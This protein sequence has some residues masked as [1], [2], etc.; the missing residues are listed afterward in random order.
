MMKFILLPV[1]LLVSLFA[2][3]QS[4]IEENM[5]RYYEDYLPEKIF[6]HTDKNIYAG[7]ET[8]WMAVYLLNGQSHLPGAFSQTVWVEIHNGQGEVVA[9]QKLFSED[10]FMAGDL[11]L[12]ASIPPGDYQLAAY[13]NYQRNSGDEMLF[14][15]TIQIL[16]GLKE[17]GGVQL[18]PS[19]PI[20]PAANFSMPHVNLRFFPEGGDC[21]DGVPCR[22]TFVAEGQNGQPY[23]MSGHLENDVDGEMAKIKTDKNGI[24]SFVYL[25]NKDRHFR[26]VLN[27]SGKTID[28]PPALEKGF[29]LR[30]IKRSDHWRLMLHTNVPQGLSGTRLVVHF[31]GYVLVNKVFSSSDGKALI[32][33]PF[34]SLRP[35]VNIATLFD[36][37]NLPVAERLFFM[38]PE[39][40][41]TD[42]EISMEQPL[43]TTRKTVNLNVKMPMDG[44]HVDSMASG[45]ISYSVL[46]EDA[47]GGPSGDDIRT[48]LLL[49]SDL[50]RPVP[51]TLELI[52]STD[53]KTRDRK[54]DEFLLT[55]GW[56]RFKWEL[57]FDKKPF[58]PPYLIEKGVYLKGRMGKYNA[59]KKPQPGRVFLTR[60]ANGYFEEYK[61]DETGH[62]VF[63][64][65]TIFDTL[66]VM[67][68]GRFNRSKKK[69]V[70]QDARKS[71]PYTHL[72]ILSHESPALPP[73]PYFQKSDWQSGAVSDYGKLSQ[74]ALTIAR[75]FDSLVI[76][77]PEVDI[78][79]SKLSPVDE[80]RKKRSALYGGNLGTRLIVDSIPGGAFQTVFDLLRRVP[81]VQ[82][83]GSFGNETIL[84]RGGTSLLGSNQPLF[85][86]D[87]FRVD[88]DFIRT[89][90]AADIDF[91]DAVI[92]ARA[93]VFG[94]GAS[95]GA[96]LVYSKRGSNYVKSTPSPGLLQAKIFGFHKA[97]EFA[98]F[99]PNAAGNSNRPDLRTTLHWRANQA[100]DGAGVVKDS[101]PTSDQKGKFIIIAQGLRLDGQPFFG[102]GEFVV[103]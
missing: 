11:D 28:L 14:R 16:P 76:V 71:T 70:K 72:E 49:N 43:Y 91:I 45:R 94:M 101:F 89:L 96:I 32:D 84:V 31:R 86:Y 93:S 78:T 61:T 67:L 92:G 8:I 99:D 40:G 17:S 19:P 30:A 102:T 4:A 29:H 41:S 98:V 73:I 48:W 62:F 47:R 10:G 81:G 20:V 52:F 68:Q 63:G 35:G 27:G 5:H 7:G 12:P 77:L 50:D 69:K 56:R 57:A 37:N 2:N 51:H 6:V 80:E 44:V 46:S 83:T 82:V 33:L 64:P 23:A 97:R 58:K 59:P 66:D 55:R 1:V 75:N 88:I 9:Q 42:L 3:A 26:A 87:G 13:T 34:N 38:A 95:N 36:Q 18:N 53:P 85:F 103:E 25:P 60:L 22:V 79:A 24:G 100:T 54:V 65:Y 39:E 21:V 90:I 15:K 74:D